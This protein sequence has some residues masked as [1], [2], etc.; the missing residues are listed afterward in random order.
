MKRYRLY[1]TKARKGLWQKHDTSVGKGMLMRRSRRVR[2]SGCILQEYTMRA[3]VEK[4]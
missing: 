4:G 2:I 1:R 3:D